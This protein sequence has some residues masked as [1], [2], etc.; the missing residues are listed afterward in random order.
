LGL[1]VTF[2]LFLVSR[3]GP[4][5]QAKF[6]GE[7]GEGT[8]PSAYDCDGDG[9][10]DGQEVYGYKVTAAHGGEAILRRKGFLRR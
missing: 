5:N 6:H 7:R 9:A 1:P 4:S 10:S 2:A 8:N 3:S